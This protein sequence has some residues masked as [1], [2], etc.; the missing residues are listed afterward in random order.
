M[1]NKTNFIIAILV[2]IV[3]FMA[4][5]IFI[6]K[7]GLDWLLSMQEEK[8][9]S[10]PIPTPSPIIAKQWDGPPLITIDSLKTYIATMQT[11]EGT[12]KIELFA[13]ETPKAVNNFVFLSKE[14]FYNG[15]KFHR[16]IKG[17]MIQGGDP[18][19]DGTGG[20]GYKFDDEKITRDYNR[21]IVAYANSGLNTNGSQFFIMHKDYAL[22]KNY[23]IFGQVIEGMET[24]DKIAETPVTKNSG[25]EI[26]K[27]TKDIIIENVTIEEK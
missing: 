25:N 21:G 4:A 12:I 13:N 6:D 27:P 14:N 20:P 15:L 2:I 8:S 11:S 18:K 24:V 1:S 23:V 5:K 19:G 10:E 22:P 26:S 7:N 3:L 16:I 17:F 9:A